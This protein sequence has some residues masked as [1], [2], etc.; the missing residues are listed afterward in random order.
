MTPSH[1]VGTGS[2]PVGATNHTEFYTRRN[3]TRRT[4]MN[5]ESKALSAVLLAMDLLSGYV[6][7]KRAQARFSAL[8]AR[9]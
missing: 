4:I 6:L 5:P 8:I 1:G 7:Y 2:N 3:Q 9:G